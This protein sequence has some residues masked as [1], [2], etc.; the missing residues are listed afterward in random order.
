LNNGLETVFKQSKFLY[1]FFDSLEDL[2]VAHA[3]TI[4]NSLGTVD[5]P[6]DKSI[7]AA[8]NE[9]P[10]GYAKVLWRLQNKLAIQTAST[11]F[12]AVYD[13]EEGFGGPGTALRL[14][15]DM[16]ESQLFNHKRLQII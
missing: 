9:L 7:N 16:I 11:L 3:E 1:H 2:V 4:T 14:I 15:I 13:S 10:P 5:I 8:L 12:L 6:T